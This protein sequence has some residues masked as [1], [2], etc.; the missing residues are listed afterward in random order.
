MAYFVGYE[1][2]VIA[3]EMR[4]GLSEDGDEVNVVRIP[5]YAFIL[6]RYRI[7]C[8]A[9]SRGG[10]DVIVHYIHPPI[11]LLQ[12][13][14]VVIETRKSPVRKGSDICGR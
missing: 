8:V 14:E 1:I 4:S 13:L 3:Q 10:A 6:L 9:Q 7:P 11:A 5:H 2:I 12:Y